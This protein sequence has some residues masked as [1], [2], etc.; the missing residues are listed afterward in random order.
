MYLSNYLE[1]GLLMWSLVY[2]LMIKVTY[3]VFLTSFRGTVIV[4]N[5]IYNEFK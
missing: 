2:L 4:A 1:L 5:S 3:V